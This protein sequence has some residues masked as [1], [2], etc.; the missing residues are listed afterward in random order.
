MRGNSYVVSGPW[1]GWGQGWGQTAAA[2]APP[3][4]PE[5]EAMSQ[6]A[7]ALSSLPIISTIVERVTDPRRRAGILRA[8]LADA[9]RRGRPLTT[10]EKLRAQLAAAEAQVQAQEEYEQQ[11]REAWALAK[12]GQATLVGIGMAVIFFILMRTVRR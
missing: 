7:T 11:K 4:E 2:E 12:V 8:Q 1:R 3:T 5:G 6:W 9:I 10:I